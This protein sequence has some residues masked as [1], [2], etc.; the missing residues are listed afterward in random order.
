MR[1]GQIV[2]IIPEKSFGF[3]A[4]DNLREDIFFHFSVVEEG[5][6]ADY[7]EPG[8]E[9]EFELDELKRMDG[10]ELRATLVRVS[11]RPQQVMIKEGGLRAFNH[12]HHPNARQRKPSWKKRSE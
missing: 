2:R 4:A 10:E 3:I 1:I 12:K 9:V 5:I 6:R 11:N 7:W 8:Q